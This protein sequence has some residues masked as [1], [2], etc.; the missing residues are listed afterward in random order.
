[1]LFETLISFENSPINAHRM[2]MR[3]II[4]HKHF[5]SSLLVVVVFHFTH[6]VNALL[7]TSQQTYTME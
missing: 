7:I 2:M 4:L 5:V 3:G 1:M 6:E